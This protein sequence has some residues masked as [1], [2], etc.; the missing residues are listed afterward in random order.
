M[1][2][3]DDLFYLKVVRRLQVQPKINAVES[4]LSGWNVTLPVSDILYWINV[5]D[6]E[7]PH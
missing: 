6:A 4:F 3:L 7:T 5:L 2:A 1:P